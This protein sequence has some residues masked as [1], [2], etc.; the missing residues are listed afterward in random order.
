MDKLQ[1]I[2]EQMTDL[3]IPYQLNEWNAPDGILKY[4]YTV[5]EFTEV[6]TMTE[7]G[8]EES[9]LL[10]TVTT[11]GSWFELEGI[12]AK[13]KKRFPAGI[14]L[15]AETDSG[16]IAVFYAGSFPV[17]TGEADLKRMQ[18]NLDIKE[19]KGLN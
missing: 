16:S 1:F 9:T 4:P 5:G 19:W 12:K 7:D 18:I 2:N 15:C 14:G 11:R 3:G 6:A 17:P 13:I 8:Y 10:L